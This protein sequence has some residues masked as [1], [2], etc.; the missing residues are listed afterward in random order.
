VNDFSASNM[1]TANSPIAALSIQIQEE[2]KSFH[3]LLFLVVRSILSQC[4]V[5]SVNY[6]LLVKMIILT[7]WTPNFLLSGKFRLYDQCYVKSDK[8]SEMS[9]SL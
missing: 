2:K 1:I 9:D 4:S 5:P 8:Y 6:D 7:T 3:N